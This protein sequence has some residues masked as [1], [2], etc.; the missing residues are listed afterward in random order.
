MYVSIHMYIY[1]YNA[2][3]Q[4][5]YVICIDTVYTT[6]VKIYKGKG[7][8]GNRVQVFWMLCK[9]KSRDTDKKLKP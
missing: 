4:I 6:F 9:L 1:I 8:L 2:C 5:N 3:M 7:G